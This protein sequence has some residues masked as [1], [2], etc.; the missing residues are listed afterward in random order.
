MS[1]F[2]NLQLSIPPSLPA[3]LHHSRLYPYSTATLHSGSARGS[4]APFW[5]ARLPTGNSSSAG[6]LLSS[7]CLP[8]V[9]A[10]PCRVLEVQVNLLYSPRTSQK[11]SK[12]S[13]E[14]KGS[15]CS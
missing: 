9:H 5:R 1:S 8:T 7:N 6:T 14:E 12:R 11:L 3:G 2:G 15:P 10:R 4:R 13:A